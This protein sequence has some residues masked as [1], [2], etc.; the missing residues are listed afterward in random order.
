MTN[1]LFVYYDGK[2]PASADEGKEVMGD[3]DNWFK[4]LGKSLVDGGSPTSPGRLVTPTGVKKIGANPVTG[5]TVVKADNL[6]AAAAIAKSG[7][8]L[9][10]GGQI[11]VYACMQM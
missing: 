7:P 11:A 10:S 5:Y 1:Y 6:D 2:Q 3:W 9:A 4:S 8:H